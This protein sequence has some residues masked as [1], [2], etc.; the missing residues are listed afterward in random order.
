MSKKTKKDEI[1]VGSVVR[2]KSG[3]PEMTVEAINNSGS[4]TCVWFNET[5]GGY[6]RDLAIFSFQTVDLL[7]EDDDG[8]WED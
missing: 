8:N 4:L 1:V 6:A 2:L 3:G 5:D 7:T